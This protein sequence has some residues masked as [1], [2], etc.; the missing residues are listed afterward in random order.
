MIEEEG[1]IEVSD[2]VGPRE[3]EE[4]EEFRR[5]KLLNDDGSG[6]QR[7]VVDGLVNQVKGPWSRNAVVNLQRYLDPLKKEVDV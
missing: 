3:E 1:D 2:V 7:E 6:V 5:E 4:I